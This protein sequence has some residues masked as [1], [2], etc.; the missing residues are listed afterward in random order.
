MCTFCGDWS[1]SAARN[2]MAAQNGLQGKGM[3]IAVLIALYM[4]IG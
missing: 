1:F 4:Y 3:M 2:A